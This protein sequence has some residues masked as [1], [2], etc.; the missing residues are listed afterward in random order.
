M[1]LA[2][3]DSIARALR[4]VASYLQLNGEN[5]FRTRAYELAAERIA[6]LTRPIDEWLEQGRLTELPG[7]GPSMAE[8][9]TELATTGHLGYLESLRAAY[10]PG[11]LSLLDVPDL[12]PKKA[13]LL[14]EGLGIRDIA[15]L[16]EAC[17]SGRVRGL[18]GFSA[19][20]EQRLLE[21]IQRHREV[22]GDGRHP[23]GEVLPLADLLLGGL[24]A[25]PGV[26]TASV[27]GS[28]RR[29]CET[30]GDLD[31]VVASS[32]PEE[33]I[34][35]LVH[36]HLVEEVLV[37]GE[38]KVSVRL[39]PMALRVDL[40]VVPEASYASA[41]HHLTGSKAHHIRLR[42]L[43]RERGVSLSEWGLSRDDALSAFSSEEE[44]YALLGLPFIPPELREDTGEIEA[45]ASGALPLDLVTEADV[46]GNVHA[47][48]TWSDGRNTLEEMVRGASALGMRYLT[49]TEHSQSAGYAGGLDEAG[50]LRQAA[51]LSRIALHVG[52][53]VELL[54]G[55]ESD[56]L[57][58]GS[59]DYPAELLSA[60]DVVIG[61]VH[62]RFHQDEESMTRRLFRALDDPNMDIWGHP[63]GR[64]LGKRA[65][66]PM[67]LSALL[68]R[69]AERGVAV[70]VNGNPERLDLKAEHVREA[71][72]RGVKLSLSTDAH[73]VDEL[74]RNL[75]YAVATARRGWAR[76][77]DVINARPRAEFA[78]SLRRGRARGA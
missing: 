5:A 75:W 77:S 21:G 9:V 25:A 65:P 56:I 73:S 34:A 47:H 43:A 76:R 16:E 13:K 70:E 64:L 71:I 14:I 29:A 27:A 33:A 20:A 42:G 69:A 22:A 59:L 62:Q 19:R 3:K 37:R 8:K 31:L 10:P 24:R 44:L 78:G 66:A 32:R 74:R 68:D 67:D 52:G 1:A 23:L 4:E 58:D 60:M 30:V 39:A 51:E 61:S 46:L 49:V 36:S 26:N 63:T 38:S 18:K 2:D 48:S 28:A 41:L 45:A 40:L 15:G 17:R 50:L 35:A 55:V 72:R 6:G 11:V 12:G 7:I 57:E 53:D 54:R